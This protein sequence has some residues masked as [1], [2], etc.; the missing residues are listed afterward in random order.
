MG[1]VIVS[2]GYPAVRAPK[3]RGGASPMGATMEAGI[4]RSHSEPGS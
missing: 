4:T 1:I 2:S 3:A